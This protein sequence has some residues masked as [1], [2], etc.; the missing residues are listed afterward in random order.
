MRTN[1]ENTVV[2]DATH[3][4]VWDGLLEVSRTRNYFTELEIT[5]S[6]RV[7]Y[8][9]LALAIA[10]VGV[11]ASLFDFFEQIRL[12]TGIAITI[13]VVIDLLWDG[14]STL[15]KLKLVNQDL[16]Y[17]EN[18]YRQIWEET[19]NRTISDEDVRAEKKS[20]LD[21]LN[22]IASKVDITPREN[23]V[24]KSQESAFN[25]EKVRYAG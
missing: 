2:T 15:A 23:I 16:V 20:L 13:L 21:T 3:N 25:A 24:V 8:L 11:F 7:F 5:F 6:R 17:L 4:A 9:R 10:G 19:L 22:K 14:T 12:I 1:L 18:E